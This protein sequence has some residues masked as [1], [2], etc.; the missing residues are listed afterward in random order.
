MKENEFNFLFESQKDLHSTIIYDDIRPKIIIKENKK[1]FA[2]RITFT[3]VMLSVLLLFL[4]TS[5]SIY[6]VREERTEYR[7]AIAFFEKNELVTNNLSKQEIKIVYVDITTGKF[8]NDLTKNVIL[9]S[10]NNKA[11]EYNIDTSIFDFLN[12]EN[13]WAEWKE[14]VYEESKNI[15]L[16]LVFE[17][18]VEELR[19]RKSSSLM[20]KQIPEKYFDKIIGCYYDKDFKNK[21][22][23]EILDNNTILYFKMLRTG[24]LII[25]EQLTNIIKEDI[26]NQTE[27]P[28]NNDSPL[29]FLYGVYGETAVY[30]ININN[31]KWKTKKIKGYVFSNESEWYIYAWNNGNIYNLENF[32]EL[33]S[34][35]ILS[36]DSLNDIYEI[37]LE[38]QKYGYENFRKFYGIEVSEND[39]ELTVNVDKTNILINDK[40]KVTT[41]FKNLT[42]RD[43]KIKLGHAT[44]ESIEDTI[45]TQSCGPTGQLNFYFNSLGGTKKEVILKANQVI[46]I[47]EELLFDDY[48]KYKVGAFVHF[49]VNEDYDT[50]IA[51]KSNVK[52]VLVDYEG[53]GGQYYGEIVYYNSPKDYKS[54]NID[55]L[56]NNYSYKEYSFEKIEFLGEFFGNVA[57]T[58]DKLYLQELCTYEEIYYASQS[59]S[60]NIELG[61]YLFRLEEKTYLFYASYTEE[62]GYHIYHGYKINKISKKEIDEHVI[63]YTNADKTDFKFMETKSTCVFDPKNQNINFDLEKYFKGSFDINYLKENYYVFCN[64]RFEKGYTQWYHIDYTNVWYVDKNTLVLKLVNDVTW[65]ERQSDLKD[66]NEETNESYIAYYD[67][68][69][70]PRKYKDI[71]ESTNQSKYS[72]QYFYCDHFYSGTTSDLN[73]ID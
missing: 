45:L 44:Y 32:D 41:V 63:Y 1:Y 59:S 22:N 16:T 33:L 35:D 62:M 64:K 29:G 48:G 26:L 53:I 58:S 50:Y 43:L 4:L 39:F 19:I 7:Q 37:H 57:L 14:I 8:E 6:L 40:I 30:F 54:K 65:E 17:D 42:D 11:E 60:G 47:E 23:G 52:E 28:V 71:I 36:I 38:C 46:T 9:N 67:I 66:S 5:V 68:I 21:Y 49:Y 34:K 72:I 56:I 24:S 27:I 69:L 10:I 61:Y 73:Y 3:T 70:V 20:L 55:I 12:L 25:D 2:K 31:T 51:I 18:V 15:T 13:I